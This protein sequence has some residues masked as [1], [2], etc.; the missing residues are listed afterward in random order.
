MVTV[1]NVGTVSTTNVHAVSLYICTCN[2]S[3]E[4]EKIM[5]QVWKAQADKREIKEIKEESDG[6]EHCGIKV[7]DGMIHY[8]FDFISFRMK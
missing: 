2:L 7:E 6:T 8:I 3:L 4:A 5:R 1:V